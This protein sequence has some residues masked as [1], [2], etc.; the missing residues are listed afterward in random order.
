MTAL[1]YT[2]ALAGKGVLQA[3]AISRAGQRAELAGAIGAD[4]ETIPTYLTTFGIG[5]L[6]CR[7]PE[8]PPVSW[9]QYLNESS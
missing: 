4:G 1:G 8:V 9:R 3:I 7:K 6:K 2:S 5:T